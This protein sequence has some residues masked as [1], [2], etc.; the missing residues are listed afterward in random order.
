ME[1]RYYIMRNKNILCNALFSL[2]E[3]GHDLY[4]FANICR[5]VNDNPQSHL[6]RQGRNILCPPRQTAFL[7][8]IYYSGHLQLAN[9]SLNL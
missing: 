9:Y 3:I 8:S 1:L 7:L 6:L 2:A 4:F 5:T